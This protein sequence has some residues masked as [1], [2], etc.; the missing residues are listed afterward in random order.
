MAPYIV[1]FPKTQ[2]FYNNILV[3][4]WESGHS[5]VQVLAFLLMRR[6]VLL[7]PQPTLNELFQVSA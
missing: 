2:K 6:I 5:Q 7:R 1:C 3:A 4:K